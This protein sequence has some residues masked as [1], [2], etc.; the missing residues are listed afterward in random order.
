MLAWNN[1]AGDYTGLVTSPSHR[2]PDGDPGCQA[3]KSRRPML[4]GWASAG[5]AG[6]G[7]ALGLRGAW[8]GQGRVWEHPASFTGSSSWELVT[9][10]AEKRWLWSCWYVGAGKGKREG[11]SGRGDSVGGALA[12]SACE[13]AGVT[14]Q[15]IPTCSQTINPRNRAIAVPQW[16]WGRAR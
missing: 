3:W 4:S 10:Q 13:L 8:R 11:R 14:W 16:P 12:N 7:P 1:L 9:S 2:G 5:S 15:A 6:L